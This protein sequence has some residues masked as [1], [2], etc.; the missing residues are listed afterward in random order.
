MHERAPSPIMRQGLKVSASLRFAEPL[1]ATSVAVA[2]NDLPR[3]S[4][5]APAA[6]GLATI[7]VDPDPTKSDLPSRVTT[8]RHMPTVHLARTPRFKTVRI[9][10]TRPSTTFGDDASAP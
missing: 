8:T 4:S 10:W 6:V 1:P 3:R 5:F 9:L 2:R 7:V